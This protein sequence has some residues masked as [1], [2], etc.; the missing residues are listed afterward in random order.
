[1]CR[2]TSAHEDNLERIVIFSDITCGQGEVEVVTTVGQS[3][4]DTSGLRTVLVI[5]IRV[6]SLTEPS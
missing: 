5:V 4:R 6:E 1:M 3:R 2:E